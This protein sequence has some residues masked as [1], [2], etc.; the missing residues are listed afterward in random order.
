MKI[1]DTKAVLRIARPNALRDNRAQAERDAQRK[2]ELEWARVL[3]ELK[4][5]TVSWLM[6]RYH[7][8]GKKL[9]KDQ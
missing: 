6:D 7:G 4:C 2:I 5:P 9:G 1:V 3:S 8:S